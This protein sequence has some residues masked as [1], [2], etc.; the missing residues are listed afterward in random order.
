M[1]KKYLDSLIDKLNNNSI[2]EEER[3]VLMRYYNSYQ[4]SAEWDDL[5]MGNQRD[6]GNHIYSRLNIPSTTVTLS[7]GKKPYFYRAVAASIIVFLLSYVSYILFFSA[8]DYIVVESGREKKVVLLSDGSKVTMNVNSKL[9]Y[10]KEF[11]STRRDVSFEGEGY[12]EVRTDANQPFVVSTK[13]LKIKV[14][15]T[16]F[17]LKAYEDD[18]I[19]EASLLQGKIEVISNDEKHTYSALKPLEK[20]VVDKAVLEKHPL[21]PSKLQ[22]E[23]VPVQFID[24]NEKAPVDVAWKEGKFAFVSVPF[25]DIAREIKRRY[26]TDI[27]FENKEVEL[28]RYTGTFEEEDVLEILNALRLVKSFSYTKEGGRIMI[29]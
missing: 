21:E 19:V 14:L 6:T 17:N 11:L 28:Y 27:V 18:P 22:M 16:T 1:D 24:T 8:S 25:A 3:D 5:L 13:Q 20:F 9:I 23:V 12:F 10:P 26:G 4:F 7:S 15:G 29:Y 2:S